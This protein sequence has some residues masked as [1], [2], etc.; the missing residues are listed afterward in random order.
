[1]TLEDALSGRN[2]PEQDG[3]IVHQEVLEALAVLRPH[4]A[5]GCQKIRV[6]NDGDGGYVCVDHF[7][8]IDTA[9]SLG[10]NN[11][12]SW[13]EDMAGR[14]ITVHQFDHTVDDPRPDDARL[15]FNKTM[16]SDYLAP[17]TETVDRL[18]G[19]FDAGRADPNIF[20]KIDIENWEWPVFDRM[21]PKSLARVSQI[22]GEFHSFE[23]LTFPQWRHRASRVLSKITD[24][25]ALVH[26]HANNWARQTIVANICVP[27]VLELSFVNRSVFDVSPSDEI[28]PGELDQ[29]CRPGHPDIFL[30]SFRFAA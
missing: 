12:V 6:G 14:G 3:R 27:N 29:A 28:F 17:G 2:P 16:I 4:E 26:V 25:F 13:D 15:I 18:I 19:L 22:V 20:L 24:Q 5:I 30:G 11:D 10:V 8:G 7:E 21:P 1:M 23:N 9:L